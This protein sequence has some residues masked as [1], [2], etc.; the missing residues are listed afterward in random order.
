MDELVPESCEYGEELTTAIKASKEAGSIIDEAVGENVDRWSKDDGSSVTE[1]DIRCQE[2]II[3]TISESFPEDGFLGEEENVSPSGEERVWVIDPIDGTFNFKKNMD[4]YCVSIALKVDDETKVA[5]VYSP[6]TSLSELYY[7]V[8]G[9]GAFV[10]E[11]NGEPIRL[12]TSEQNSVSDSAI[13]AHILNVYDGNLERGKRFFTDL[14]KEGGVTREIGTCA[15][16][17]CKVASGR[18][19]GSVHT[20]VKEWDFTASKLILEEAGGRVRVRESCYPS[21]FEVVSSNGEIQ[22]E[23]EEIVSDHFQ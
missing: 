20:I 13:Y 3:E 18:A 22:K 9:L 8:K 21:S 16:E 6:E 7:A 19:D 2:K 23:L 1:I 15:L 10:V 4:F 17:M 14:M 5:V 12:H 11:G